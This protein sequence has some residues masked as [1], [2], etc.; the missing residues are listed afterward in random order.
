[1]EWT[2]I[3]VAFLVYAAT[4]PQQVLLIDNVNRVVAAA[5]K[6]GWHLSRPPKHSPQTFIGP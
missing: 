1:M 2:I 3:Y 4:S 6:R 5:G